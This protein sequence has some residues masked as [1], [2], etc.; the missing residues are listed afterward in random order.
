MDQERTFVKMSP[1]DFFL[2]LALV[3]TLYISVVSVLA[4]MFQIINMAFPDSLQFGYGYNPYSDGIRMAIASLLVIFPLYLLISWIMN[5]DYAISPDK[6][7][8][9]VRKW[10]IYL[11]LFLAG[12]AVVT[13]L[14]V[15]INTFLG[16]EITIRF[17]LKVLSVLLVAGAVFGYY[18]YDLKEK[19]KSNQRKLFAISAAV[20][21]LLAIV[22]GFVFM[23]SPATQRKIKADNQK[24]SD[25]QQLESAIIYEY[26]QM[27]GSL[28]E[29]LDELN[30]LIRYIPLVDRETNEPYIYNKLSDLS[31][32]LC[33]EFN[34]SSD[35]NS[36]TYPEMSYRVGK[37]GNWNHS[38][39]EYCFERTIDPE[40]YPPV[41]PLRD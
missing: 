7:N 19:I 26:W 22:L 27:K 35:Q 24:I 18:F 20:L 41:K 16:G 40:L 13:D 2:Q 33:A 3:A 34:L 23:G 1:K 4:L 39:G 25:L 31:F 37:N 8:F 9:T 29:S 15:L 14:I 6:K 28:P 12:I 38:A 17:I 30:S 32:E 21:V 36:S 10:L 11:T 5:R